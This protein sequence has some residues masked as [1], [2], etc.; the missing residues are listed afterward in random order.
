LRP[1]ATIIIKEVDGRFHFDLN[2]LAT[3]MYKHLGEDIGVT[4][5]N[6]VRPQLVQLINEVMRTPK[7]DSPVYTSLNRLVQPR[8]S[9]AEFER[10]VSE[11]EAR[12]ERADAAGRG[13]DRR[14]PA[15]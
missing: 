14:Q 8:L 15:L 4:E 9:E 3:L 7:P 13:G 2:H 5:A 6:K 10:R 1:Y 11:A 12:Q